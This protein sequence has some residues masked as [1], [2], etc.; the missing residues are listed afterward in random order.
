MRAKA[1]RWTAAPRSR[2]AAAGAGTELSQVLFGQLAPSFFEKR[3]WLIV[4]DGSLLNGVPFSSLPDM[5]HPN[6]KLVANHTLRFLPSELLLLVP[7][8]E[9]PG[10]AFIGVA[11][12]IY[13]LAD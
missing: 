12:P 13:N 7:G 1:T 5:S 6:T 10:L 4:G 9:S 8:R 11:D 2:R 3:E